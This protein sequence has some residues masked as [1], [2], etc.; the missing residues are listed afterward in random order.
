[1]PG[2][3]NLRLSAIPRY[4]QL[5]NVMYVRG[6]DSRGQ[7]ELGGPPHITGH[8]EEDAGAGYLSIPRESLVILR[9]ETVR[10]SFAFYTRLAEQQRKVKRERE[11]ERNKREASTIR[12]KTIK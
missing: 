2:S 4:S 11:K 6:K 8:T 5:S 3:S 12:C 9:S 10:L 1:M 7:N